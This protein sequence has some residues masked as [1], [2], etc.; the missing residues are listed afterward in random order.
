MD[1][2]WWEGGRGQDDDGL[3][4]WNHGK[5]LHAIAATWLDVRAPQLAAVRRSVLIISTD[6][7]HNTSDAFGQKFGKDPTAVAGF[8]NLFCMEV[9][10]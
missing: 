5:L 4:R 9:C 7:A 2:C 10:V 1:F 8:T 6:P 3:L